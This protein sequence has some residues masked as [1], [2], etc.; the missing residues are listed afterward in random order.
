MV[1]V[2]ELGKD[3]QFSCLTC[4]LKK[5]KTKFQR[6]SNVCLWRGKREPSLWSSRRDWEPWEL[7]SLGAV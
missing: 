3:R 2:L 6:V 5:G 4:G 1:I 7:P